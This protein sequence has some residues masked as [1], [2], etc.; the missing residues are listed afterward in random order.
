MG[1]LRIADL[2]GKSTQ[3]NFKLMLVKLPPG[4]GPCG[5]GVD[6]RSV[7]TARSSFAFVGHDVNL[8][9]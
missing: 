4:R 2:R 6:S 3:F 9:I 8:H 5:S 7:E 1:K